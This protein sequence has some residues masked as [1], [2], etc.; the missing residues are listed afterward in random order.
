MSRRVHKEFEVQAQLEAAAGLPVTFAVDASN[1][2][3]CAQVV[4]QQSRD[5]WRGGI[6]NSFLGGSVLGR[7]YSQACKQ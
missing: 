4:S 3:M 1:P 5:M 6:G 2:R 7:E